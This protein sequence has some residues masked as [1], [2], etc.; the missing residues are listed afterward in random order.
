MPGTD[1]RDSRDNNYGS[2]YFGPVM[3]MGTTI[4]WNHEVEIGLLVF[5]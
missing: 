3:A 2:G 1:I 5:R 4:F